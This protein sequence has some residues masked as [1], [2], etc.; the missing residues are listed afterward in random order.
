MQQGGSLRGGGS[1]SSY[2]GEFAAMFE[3]AGGAV[4]QSVFFLLLLPSYLRHTITPP[5]SPQKT[6]QT[7]AGRPP[8][9]DAVRGGAQ[10][11]R[12]APH[13][14]PPAGLPDVHG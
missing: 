6:K 12:A 14:L 2:A 3:A 4:S 8:H 13:L 7:T 5:P 10:G 9:G 1:G 11:G